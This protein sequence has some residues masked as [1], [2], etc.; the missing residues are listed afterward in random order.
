MKERIYAVEQIYLHT[1][2]A[3][4]AIRHQHPIG[5]TRIIRFEEENSFVNEAIHDELVG[6]FQ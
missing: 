2:L 4:K 1:G 5:L 6:A 3:A